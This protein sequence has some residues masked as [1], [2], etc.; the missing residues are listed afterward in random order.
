MEIAVPEQAPTAP[1][2]EEIARD[3]SAPLSGTD[4]ALAA[5]TQ[6]LLYPAVNNTEY[7]TEK[8]P[9]IVQ[10][11]Q[12]VEGTISSDADP[13]KALEFDEKLSKYDDLLLESP[14][15][16]N[17]FKTWVKETR[18]KISERPKRRLITLR[19]EDDVCRFFHMN[20]IEPISKLPYNPSY[21][22][23]QQSKL[24]RYVK[25]SAPAATLKSAGLHN[26]NSAQLAE[27]GLVIHDLRIAQ[28]A[29]Q[30]LLICFDTLQ[31]L[32]NAGFTRNNFDSRLWTLKGISKAY[33][34]TRLE[35]ANYFGMNVTHLLAAG[36]KP[37]HMIEYGISND[38]IIHSDKAFNILLSLRLPLQTLRDEYKFS[39]ES[40]F[41]GNEPRFTEPQI[42]T[43]QNVC[44]WTR[45]DFE[46][47]FNM[48]QTQLR[49]LRLGVSAKEAMLPIISK[50]KSGFF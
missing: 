31:T 4:A 28:Y 13:S 32:E 33:N 1:T 44:N 16:T 2:E 25:F 36:V 47:V 9:S 43:L 39:T 38:Q 15:T 40:F 6:G 26:L 29:P 22:S 18:R 21:I 7:Y 14:P 34:K 30:D 35:V 23:S 27:Q 17:W 37:N 41:N 24:C 5:T 50:S 45:S 49:K 19:T 48:D 42:M 10:E 8:A 11:I 3:V 46:F 20:N 12:R